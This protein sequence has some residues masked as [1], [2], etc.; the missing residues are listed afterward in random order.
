MKRNKGDW[1]I[2]LMAKNDEIRKLQRENE[3]LKAALYAMYMRCEFSIPAQPRAGHTIIDESAIDN[4]LDGYSPDR[5]LIELF[6]LPYF[7]PVTEAQHKLSERLR[8]IIE[9]SPRARC[10]LTPKIDRADDDG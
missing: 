3:M 7:G 4:L 5:E 10:R 6:E 2:K 1:I 8:Q 9:E